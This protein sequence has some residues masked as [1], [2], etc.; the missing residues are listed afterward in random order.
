MIINLKLSSKVRLS[1][2]KWNLAYRLPS[3]KTVY[4]TPWSRYDQDVREAL[5]AINMSSEDK[6]QIE[7]HHVSTSCLEYSFQLRCSL[8][9]CALFYRMPFVR[10]TAF[11]FTSISTSFIHP[12]ILS[13]IHSLICSQRKPN[14]QTLCASECTRFVRC[15]TGFFLLLY[16]FTSC[17]FLWYRILLFNVH[18]HFN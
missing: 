6:I 10:V 18:S 14:V 4:I 3:K 11:R 7:P 15:F 16:F 2:Q 1:F 17:Q 12:F 5:S 8:P 13:S 9:M